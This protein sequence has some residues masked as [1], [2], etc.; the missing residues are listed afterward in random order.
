MQTTKS[1]KIMNKESEQCSEV[2][3]KL[4]KDKA[5]ISRQI[6]KLPNRIKSAFPF[7]EMRAELFYLL[8]KALP[9]FDENKGALG[10][11]IQVVFYRSMQKLFQEKM[12][13]NKTERSISAAG[14][15]YYNDH[16]KDGNQELYAY[17]SSLPEALLSD[18]T[19]FALG[20]KNRAE[21]ISNPAHIKVDVDRV[22][23]KLDALV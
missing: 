19:E 18:L 22:L 5:F 13:R 3:E 14:S 6:C 2:I 20:K 7:S 12:D 21:I 4:A 10:D 15:L 9:K 8:V 16:N 23:S 17:L 11:Y 1:K